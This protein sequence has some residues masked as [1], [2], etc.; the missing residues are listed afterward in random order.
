MD[1]STLLSKKLNDKYNFLKVLKVVYNTTFS[2]CQIN[3]IYPENIPTLSDI[4]KA[5]IKQAV[6][7]VLGLKGKVECKFNK[8]YLDEN[9]VKNKIIDFFQSDFE[10]IS[11]CINANSIKYERNLFAISLTFLVNDTLHKYFLNNNV[12]EKLKNYLNENFCGDFFVGVE[13]DNSEDFDEQ[14]LETRAIFVQSNIEV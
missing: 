7:D 13:I 3:F 10:S 1:F 9:I 11:S 12:C 2:L 6:Q 5:E 14:M 8:S 4:Q